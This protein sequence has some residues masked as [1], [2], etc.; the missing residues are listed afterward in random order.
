MVCAD[1]NRDGYLDLIFAS[2]GSPDLVIFYGAPGGFDVDNPVRIRMELDGEL[3]DEPRWIYLADW[4]NDGWLDLFVPQIGSD[5]S[6]ILWGG[7]QGFSMDRLQVL[8]VWHA[9]CARAAD[10]NGNGYL[11]LIVGGH[12][13]LA[14]RPPRL[15]RAR[16]LERPRRTARRQQDPAAR[17][18]HQLNRGRRLRQRRPP[19]PL[20][21]LI[22]RRSAARHRL[23]PLLAA[24][25]GLLRRRPDT[26]ADPL[27][28][29]VHSGRLRRQ[30]LDRPRD[31][32]PPRR[33][34]AQGPLG[35]LVERP[36]GLL[37]PPR[38]HPAH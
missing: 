24:R 6:F 13:P 7:P 27:R 1:I 20:R 35:G 33:G 22:P 16:L 12:E 8:S 23:L 15:L 18:R 29:R 4:N 26:H 14:R 11:D 25:D 10:L 32:V 34:G 5:R 19:R 9:A 37:G 2:I 17:Q 36:R 38:H 28:L 31:R 30:R 21:G 3:Y